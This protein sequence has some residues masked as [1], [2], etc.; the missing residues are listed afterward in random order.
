MMHT[1]SSFALRR[2]GPQCQYQ[3]LKPCTYS[4]EAGFRMSNG[5]CLPDVGTPYFYEAKP[6]GK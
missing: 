6:T 2:Y 1:P 5:S 4:K 3:A